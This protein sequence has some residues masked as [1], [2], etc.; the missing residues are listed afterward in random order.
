MALWDKRDQHYQAALEAYSY[1]DRL[2]QMSR[3]VGR[4]AGV[5]LG[6]AAVA[7]DMGA[8]ATALDDLELALVQLRK[9][10]K[11]RLLKR[12]ESGRCS[13]RNQVDLDH[14]C[15]WSK[16]PPT[17]RVDHTSLL[18]RILQRDTAASS[19]RRYRLVTHTNVVETSRK[20]AQVRT[21]V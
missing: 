9:N 18:S 8:P 7:A 14:C 20:R 12:N 3:P 21:L 19:T 17:F 1:A 16:M 10:A 6:R 5:W 15:A 4:S 11:V 2:E 13:H